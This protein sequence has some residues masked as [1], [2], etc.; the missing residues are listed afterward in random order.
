M[1]NQ[2]YEDVNSEISKSYRSKS[3]KK[4]NSREAI[5]QVVLLKNKVLM[6]DQMMQRSFEEANNICINNNV[7]ETRNKKGKPLVRGNSH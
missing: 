1:R 2:K 6:I 3:P 4:D 7:N 5:R